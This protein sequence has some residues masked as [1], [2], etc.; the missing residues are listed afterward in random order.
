MAIGLAVAVIVGAVLVV[1][2]VL[3][4]GSSSST[5]AADTRPITLPDSLNGL[6]NY[7]ATVQAKAGSSG[8]SEGPMTT[9][10]H[11]V[12][13]TET[14]YQKAFAGAATTVRSYATSDLMGIYTVIAVR[15]S[16]PRLVAGPINN[17]ADLGLARDQQ[18]IETIGDQQCNVVSVEVVPSGHTVDSSKLLTAACQRTGS[19]LTV[20]AFGGG[21]DGPA[22]QAQITGLVDAAY[23]SVSSGK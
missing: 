6:T 5:A 2:E 19:G 14:A 15:A 9:N 23:A 11:M 10:E 12:S 7:A 16:A 3:H 21:V 17:P 4:F 20:W 8:R 13:L 18:A 1:T 22:G